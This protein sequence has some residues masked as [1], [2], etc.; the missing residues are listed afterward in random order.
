VAPFT[1]GTTLVGI[2]VAAWL[3]KHPVSTWPWDRI[4]PVIIIATTVIVALGVILLR[5][6]RRTAVE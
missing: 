4:W 1:L 5:R 3:E 6:W 2:R